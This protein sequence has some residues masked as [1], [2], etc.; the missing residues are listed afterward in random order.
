MFAFKQRRCNEIPWNKEVE[1]TQG[2]KA[3]ALK[4]VSGRFGERGCH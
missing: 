2:R 4:P 3:T 1:M